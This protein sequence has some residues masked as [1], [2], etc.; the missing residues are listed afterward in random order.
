MERGKFRKCRVRWIAIELDAVKDEIERLRADRIEQERNAVWDW[1]NATP[2]EDCDAV[3]EIEIAK[4]PFCAATNDAAGLTLLAR[5]ENGLSELRTLREQLAG[6][7]SDLQTRLEAIKQRQGALTSRFDEPLAAELEPLL[8]R[9]R[10]L[11]AQTQLMGMMNKAE[12]ASVSLAE[13]VVALRLMQA[14]AGTDLREDAS[15]S[16]SVVASIRSGERLVVI[17]TDDP[18]SEFIPVVHGLSGFGYVARTDL[19]Q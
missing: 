3:P 1:L 9:L 15:A 4:F 6:Q 17:E 18:Q 11:D 16:A 2:V 14:S 19:E 8:A 7:L 5:H 10:E 12:L 13:P